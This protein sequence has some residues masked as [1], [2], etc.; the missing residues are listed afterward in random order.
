MPTFEFKYEKCE[1]KFSLQ[2]CVSDYSR[3]YLSSVLSLKIIALK[4]SYK[5]L[6][7]VYLMKT[8]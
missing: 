1:A 6:W 2:L 3:K 8:T 4:E 7:L 5:E